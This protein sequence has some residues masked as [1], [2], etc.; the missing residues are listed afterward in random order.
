M[1]IYT[2]TSSDEPVFVDSRVCSDIPETR[3]LLD[4]QH[5]AAVRSEIQPNA[6]DSGQVLGPAVDWLSSGNHRSCYLF[7]DGAPPVAAGSRYSNPPEAVAGAD[8]RLLEAQIWGKI[9]K[10]P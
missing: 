6:A 1:R 9:K 5:F 7:T 8:L 10:P 2:A 3:R 4:L